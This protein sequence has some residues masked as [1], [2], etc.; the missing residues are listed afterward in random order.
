MPAILIVDDEPNLRRMLGALLDLEAYEVHE[1]R[2]AASGFARALEV[3][4]DLVLL[5]LMMPN[6]TDG[7][8]LLERLRDH[9]PDVPV[10]MMSGR[11]TLA[12]AVEAARLGAVNFLEKPLRPEALLLAI[13]NAL[14]LRQGRRERA[15][16][17]ADL[18]LAGELVGPSRAM[19]QLRALIAR[20]G[21]TDARVLVTGESGTGKAL[22]AAALHAASARRDKPLVR[23]HCP[24]IPLDAVDAELYGHEKGARPGATDR[25]IGRL[26]LAHG[27]TILFDEV[28]AL[29]LE[30]QGRLVRALEAKEMQRLGGTRTLR[31]DARVLATSSTDLARAVREGRFREDLFFQLDVV[32]IAVPP[33]REHPDDVPALVAHFTTRERR[34]SGQPAPAWT[35]EA[36]DRLARHRWPG[37]VRELANIVERLAILCAGRPITAADVAAVLPAD[38][39]DPRTDPLPDA[40]QLDVALADAL[41]DFE[42]LL[43]R[44]ALSAAGGV[45]AEAARRLQTDRPNLY[46]RMKR[47]GIGDVG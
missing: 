24:A 44:R 13:A 28:G 46:R 2:D 10:V 15:A 25:R 45:V 34:R 7:F 27:G 9:F 12:D 17:R 30:A 47:L 20:V 36:L 23:V 18:G 38:A 22:V 32:P 33:L 43:I 37:N 5:D 41:D 16:L 29:P 42:R 6:P 39:D 31:V 4:P 3:D 26:E 19:E 8:A 14:E 1:A 35:P 40:A 21:A 11:A